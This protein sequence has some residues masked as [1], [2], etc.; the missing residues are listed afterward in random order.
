MIAV[1]VLESV[2]KFLCK[3]N[4][5]QRPSTCRTI[6]W[7][8]RHLTAASSSHQRVSAFQSMGKK[9]SVEARLAHACTLFTDIRYHWLEQTS[10]V[11]GSPYPLLED[12]SN[13]TL[14]KARDNDIHWKRIAMHE[15]FEDTF[16][17]CVHKL[18]SIP[19]PMPM[20]LR[21]QGTFIGAATIVRYAELCSCHRKRLHG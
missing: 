19:I 21:E 20:S 16:K 13:K 1:F 18:D 11:P 12:S 5:L 8:K 4:F 10:Q 14:N 9:K 7:F 6:P 15:M 17:A 2:A 3:D